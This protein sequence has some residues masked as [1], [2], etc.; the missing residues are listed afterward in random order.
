MGF[1]TT[2]LILND[3]LGDIERNPQQFVKDLTA[4]ISSGADSVRHYVLGQ[5]EVMPTAHAGVFR[6]YGTQANRIMELSP[7]SADTMELAN[8]DPQSV[9]DWIQAARVQ[10]V[11]LERVVQIL[12]DDKKAAGR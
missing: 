2:I 9:L 3:R 5:T 8:R 6:L 12:A 4:A 11:A 10:M 7:R 1:N